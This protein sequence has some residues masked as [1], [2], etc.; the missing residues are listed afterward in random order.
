MIEEEVGSVVDQSADRQAGGDPL[1]LH[2]QLM[3]CPTTII[4]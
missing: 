1:G 3:P 2:N 4:K